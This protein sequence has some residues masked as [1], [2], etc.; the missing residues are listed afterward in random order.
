[1][2]E[3]TRRPTGD[4]TANWTPFPATPTTRWDKVDEVIPTDT[5]YISTSTANTQTFTF[6]A[7]TVPAGSTIT[8]LTIYYRH[9]KIGGGTCNIRSALK[10]GGTYYTTTDTGVN[11]TQG[12]WNTRSYDYTISP[13]TSA[14]WTVADIKGVGANPLQAFGVSSSDATPTVY[15]SQCYAVVTYIPP[16]LNQSI[17]TLGRIL[18]NTRNMKLSRIMN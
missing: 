18:S 11:P 10:I 3:E 5:D 1:M 15:C 17:S 2:A 4:D 12:A 14:A 8:N 13:R 9:E 6:T 7:F 16:V